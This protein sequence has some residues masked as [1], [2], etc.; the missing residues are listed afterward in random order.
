LPDPQCF[1]W[2]ELPGSLKGEESLHAGLI[3]CGLSQSDAAQGLVGFRRAQRFKNRDAGWRVRFFQDDLLGEEHEL[4]E[5]S[6]EALH[7]PVELALRHLAPAF[8]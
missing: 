4:G 6:C 1:I 7:L 3:V 2:G 8:K 5:A